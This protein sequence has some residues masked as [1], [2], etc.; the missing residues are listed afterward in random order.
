MLVIEGPCQELQAVGSPGQPASQ[1]PGSRMSASRP[2]PSLATTLS[3]TKSWPVK[4]LPEKSGWVE[5]AP[6][7]VAPVTPESSTAVTTGFRLDAGSDVRNVQAAGKSATPAL[8]GP[9]ERIQ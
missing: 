5:G 3:V 1:S 4:S 6:V 7:V 9:R 8:A 2:S